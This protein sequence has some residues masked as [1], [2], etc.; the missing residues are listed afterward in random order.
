MNYNVVF[1]SEANYLFDSTSIKIEKSIDSVLSY[2]N[3]VSIVSLDT[4]TTSL[5]IF[6]ATPL[7][8]Q[9][10][11]KD[12]QF[13][14]DLTTIKKE[15]I[16][17]VLEAT[18]E[19]TVVGHNLKYDYK[20]LL[21]NYGYRLKGVYDTMLAE[22]V[23]WNGYTKS[24]GYYSLANVCFKHLEISLEKA[25]R[26]TFKNF[27]G[28]FNDS[29]IMYAAADVMVPIEIRAKQSFRI[30]K[31]GLETVVYLENEVMKAY[32]EIEYNGMNLD[33]DKWLEL[34]EK[35]LV[36]K[37]E[38]LDDLNRY[39]TVKSKEYPKLSRFLQQSLFEEVSSSINWASSKQVIEVFETFGEIDLNYTDTKKNETRKSVSEMH[40]EKYKGENDLVDKL[41]LYRELE[42][43][44]GAFGK[45]YLKYVQKHTG[46]IH[47]TFNQLRAQTGRV[48]S[49]NPNMQQMIGDAEYRHCFVASEGYKVITA[50]Y[51]QAELRIVA[52][53]SN[54]EV[55]IQGFKENKDPYGAVGTLMFGVP[56]S[57]KENKNLRAIA[58]AIVLGLN[59]G[60]GA[61]KLA[62]KVKISMDEARKHIK[63]FEKAMPNLTD[64]LK[65]SNEFAREKGFTK[66]PPPFNRVR[67]LY[68]YGAK[69]TL[70][71]DQLASI[72]RKGQNSP[73]QG[74]N[75]D[76]TKLATVY[77]YRSMLKYN[78]DFGEGAVKIINQV[79]DEIV[80]EAR[81]DIASLVAVDM[82]RDM[83]E[84]GELIYKK[85]EMAVEYEI[86]DY[87]T[88]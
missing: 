1:V 77:I 82:E 71:E 7:L 49:S 23:C 76:L 8:L 86:E 74:G 56:V 55:W 24:K 3:P 6:E 53:L 85:I 14:I 16:L 52:E 63:A 22:Q 51:S 5:N 54:E 15:D 35:N 33:T 60:M 46:K 9:L 25:V 57:K 38:A 26:N 87:W 75:A 62:G 32:G 21:K 47:T 37:K 43:K 28:V 65:T 72:G 59:Y 40:L 36:R 66:T 78:K 31:W 41:L 58:K 11:D 17:K 4:E 20:I 50:D 61:G 79:H 18:N 88:K 67:F 68:K 84:A 27:N 64:F 80:V 10:G 29:Q 30:T 69:D 12:K 83:I 13:V 39:I 73:I 19:K 81:E 70:T 45:D 34:H 44:T 42:K 48:S 2:L